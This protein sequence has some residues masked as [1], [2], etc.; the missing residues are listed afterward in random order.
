MAQLSNPA[1]AQHPLPADQDAKTLAGRLRSIDDDKKLTEE[2][3]VEQRYETFLAYSKKNWVARQVVLE[4]TT[5]AEEYDRLIKAYEKKVYEP[6]LIPEGSKIR[7]SQLESCIGDALLRDELVDNISGNW[8]GSGFIFSIVG[9]LLAL[10]VRYGEDTEKGEKMPRR[11][12]FSILKVAAGGGFFL[13]G[14][15]GYAESIKR[16]DRLHHL[17][18]N[19]RYLDRTYQLIRPLI[20]P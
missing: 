14:T 15:L 10:A 9:S 18:E 8:L 2:Q 7:I 3:Q 1:K 12:F 16:E 4:R 5:F 19:A 11:E 20:H 13:G 17:Q 6:F